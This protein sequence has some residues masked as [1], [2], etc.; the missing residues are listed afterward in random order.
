MA[1]SS[2]KR[3]RWGQGSVSHFLHTVI[4]FI[5]LLLFLFEISSRTPIPLFR[6]ESEQW[7]SE[8]RRLGT[9]VPNE[10]VFFIN[11]NTM[12]GSIIG[13]LRHRCGQGCTLVICNLGH[14]INSPAAPAGVSTPDLSITRSP[15]RGGDVAVYVFDT[16]RACPLLFIRFL[17][18][19]LSTWPFQL[20]FIP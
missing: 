5:C 4:Y 2:R 3:G 10:L 9:S 6:P 8:L 15:S 1:S 11:S 17:C 19:C 14:L 16:N 7:L 18:L 12:R 13:P 20:Y